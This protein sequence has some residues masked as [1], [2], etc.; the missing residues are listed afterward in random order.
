MASNGQS[1]RF[2]AVVIGAGVIG[3]ATAFELSKRGRRVLCVDKLQAA[4]FG[5]TVNSCAI[6]R[7]TYSTYAGVALAYEGLQYWLDWPQYLG[8]DDELGLIEYKQCGMASL[9]DPGAHYLK[10]L[11]HFDAIGV[12]YEDWSTEE[13][14][15]RMPILDPGLFGPPKRPDDPNFWADASE[16]LPG[17]IFTPEAGYVS[18]PQLTTHNLQRAAEAAGAQF[19]FGTTVTAIRKGDDRVQG[20]TLDASSDVDAPVVVNVAGP[21]SFVINKMAGVY[22]SMNIKTRALR[23][24]VHHTPGPS[25]FDFEHDGFNVADDDNGI[26]F[27]PETSNHILIGST[28]PHCDPQDWVDPDDYDQQL[29]AEQWE[30]QVLR[31]NRRLPSVGVPHNRK[32][33]VDLY[34]VSDDWIP[35]YDRTDLDGFYVAIG[36][37]GN[38]FKNAGVAGHC[39]AE[40]IEAVE[41]G[42]DH[43]NSPLVI[44]G[45]YTGLDIDMGT[46]SR[47]REINLNS[48]MSVHG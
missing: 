39:M 2:D 23:H 35:I 34:D 16:Q 43:D 44:R 6:V 3:A 12:Q 26:Y 27:R 17:A 25:E 22:D 24:E 4:G 21:H 5:S 36:T 32:G 1:A 14:C 28:D 15:R 47:N 37:S 41:S 40:L 29:S 33:V 18:D 45:R 13:L 20:V 19:R 7:F 30:A 42:Y 11:P 38:Q 8:A 46:F 9:K 31:L 10:V 48:S